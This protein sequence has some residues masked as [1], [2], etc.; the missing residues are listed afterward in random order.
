MTPLLCQRLLGTMVPVDARGIAESTLQVVMAPI[1]VGMG[2][3]KLFPKTVRRARPPARARARGAIGQRRAAPL[4]R[5]YAR[6]ALPSSPHAPVPRH[7]TQLSPHR[8]LPPNTNNSN[9]K[10][11]KQNGASR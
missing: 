3:N 6:P 7:S 11:I 5:A 8:M 2:L 1:V 9:K 10:Q 4:P